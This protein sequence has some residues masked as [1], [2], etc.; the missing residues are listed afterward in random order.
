MMRTPHQSPRR[1]RSTP[2]PT[3]TAVNLPL[4]YVHVVKLPSSNE[5]GRGSSTILQHRPAVTTS[6]YPVRQDVGFGYSRSPSPMPLVRPPPGLDA[7]EFILGHVNT[8]LVQV[9]VPTTVQLQYPPPV[10]CQEVNAAA[11]VNAGS[12]LR[13]APR[14]STS[15]AGPPSSKLKTDRRNVTMCSNL[16]NCRFGKDCHFA[17]SRE[18]LKRFTKE[19]LTQT[20]K[21]Y[22]STVCFDHTMLGTW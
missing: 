20:N 1:A 12:S 19:E 14:S 2:S 7:V 18:E 5:L 15:A 11:A 17:H 4:S 6:C 10:F 16:S 8:V 9:G 22:L 13:G 3:S 21:S